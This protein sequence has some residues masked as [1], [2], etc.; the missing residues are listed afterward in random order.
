MIPF[1]S[2]NMSMDS[3]RFNKNLNSLTWPA[4]PLKS[5]VASPLYA[6]L[7]ILVI[8]AFHQ[9][10]EKAVLWPGVS[11]PWQGP[12]L[13]LTGLLPFP[14]IHLLVCVLP[15]HPLQCRLLLLSIMAPCFLSG[16]QK[17]RKSFSVRLFCSQEGKALWPRT[18]H[19]LFT[20]EAPVHRTVHIYGMRG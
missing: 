6:L 17:Q 14:W 9:L 1:S 2:A 12:R 7:S 16:H 19:V 20:G 11:F 8:P 15:D 13:L 18:M 4:R 3:H 5:A 10:P